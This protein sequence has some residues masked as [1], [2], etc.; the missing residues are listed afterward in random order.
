MLK[1]QRNIDITN[2]S[3][4]HTK[5]KSKYYYEFK[6]DL[7]E[8]KEVLKFADKN[9]LKI[10]IVWWWT[11][12]LFAFDVFN[13]IVIKI[14]SYW[15]HYDKDSKIL[16]VSAWEKISDIA[17]I[18]ENKYHNTLWHRFIWL[19][20]TVGGAV[21]W[22]AGCFGLETENNFLK[23]ELFDLEDYTLKIFDK[24]E[25]KFNYRT[26][27]IKQKW[28]YILLNSYF[29]LSK[30]IEKYHSSV[31]NIYFRKNKQ[32]SWYT[33]GSFFK[34]PSKDNSAWMLIEKV[35]LK[36]YKHNGA[37]FSSKHANFLMSD[38]TA[39]Y[40]D[41]LELKDFAKEKIKNQLNIDLQEEIRIIYSK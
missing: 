33:C 25:M 36:W 41:L 14:S 11:N 16:K 4:F 39:K 21:A 29:D 26:S 35:W 6:D 15:Y 20:W 18:L 24:T 5:A 37:Y 22:N 23:A 1:I 28:K 12:L 30:K 3:N 17:E 34:N 38:G 7:N 32:P 31:D 8:L 13:G 10:L 27:I 40:N 19:P 9:N 2:L